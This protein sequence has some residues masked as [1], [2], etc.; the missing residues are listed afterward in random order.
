MRETASPLNVLDVRLLLALVVAAAVVAPI[1][2]SAPS[3]TP[4]L[5]VSPS[6]VRRGGIVTF[7]G[8][9]CR[10]GETVFLISRLFPGHAFGG[11]GAITTIARRGG[12]FTRS[13]RVRLTTQRRRYVI[14]AR[15][16][17]GNLGVAVY[18]RVR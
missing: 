5:H 13:F 11:E 2:V 1:G 4:A 15:C 12:Y 14:T 10:R 8:A 3:S 9:G 7:T 17:G 16:G 6:S 18:L